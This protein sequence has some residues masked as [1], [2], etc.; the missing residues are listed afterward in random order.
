MVSYPACSYPAGMDKQ[1][2]YHIC[3]KATWEEAAETEM[4][5][6]RT[7]WRTGSFIF[8]PRIR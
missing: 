4:L 7:R 5:R 1:F 8:Q 2:I 3:Q 6:L